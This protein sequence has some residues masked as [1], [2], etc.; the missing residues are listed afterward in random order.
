MRRKTMLTIGLLGI[1]AMFSGCAGGGSGKGISDEPMRLAQ[2]S[3]EAGLMSG[4]FVTAAARFEE[5]LNRASL[6]DNGLAVARYRYQL[7][8]CRMAQGQVAEAELLLKR[9]RQEALVAG[10]AGLAARADGSAARLALDQGK[11]DESER[12]ARGALDR[13]VAD[14]PVR[15]AADLRLVLAEAALRRNEAKRARE[16]LSAAV[17]TWGKTGPD[18]VFKALVEGIQGRLL[19]LDG[20]AAGAARIFDRESGY[21]RGAK[22]FTDLAACL[23]RSARAWKD[24]GDAS[25]AAQRMYRAARIRAALGQTAKSRTLADEAEQWASAAGIPDLSELARDL[26]EDSMKKA[27]AGPEAGK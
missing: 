7:A 23:E 2:E 22:R 24:A 17:K 10:D 4:D 8:V 1:A 27:A 5:A 16:E 18:P 19:R 25:G 20:D 26:E 21:W 13:L 11:I 12:L 3:G 14:A 6:L 9:A 15:L